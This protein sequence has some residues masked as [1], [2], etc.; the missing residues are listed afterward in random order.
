MLP[1][2][3]AVI[4]VAY[5]HTVTKLFVREDPEKLLEELTAAAG[6]KK[7][8]PLRLK[9][10]T[11]KKNNVA[12]AGGPKG[13]EKS[14]AEESMGESQENASGSASEAADEE[15]QLLQLAT[16]QGKIVSVQSEGKKGHTKK[17]ISSPTVAEINVD[18]D[19]SNGWTRVP[20]KEEETV[21]TLKNKISSL[22]LQLEEVQKAAEGGKSRA[23]KEQKRAAEAEK[24]LKERTRSYQLRWVE[25]ESELTSLRSSKSELMNKL[26]A[27]LQQETKAQI[28]AETIT[29]LQD[30]IILLEA[31][32]AQIP[33]LNDLISA[34]TKKETQLT[35]EID[36]LKIQLDQTKEGISLEKALVEQ[37]RD[38]ISIVI[39][40]RT[41]LALQ[42]EQAKVEQKASKAKLETVRDELSEKDKELDLRHTCIQQLEGQLDSL[43]EQLERLDNEKKSLVDST[44]I[45]ELKERINKVV[46]SEAHLNQ[47]LSESDAKITR[48][49]EELDVMQ[50]EKRQLVQELAETRQSQEALLEKARDN[51]SSAI[52]AQEEAQAIEK[53]ELMSK[54]QDSEDR[55][56]EI[57]EALK[58]SEKKLE[59]MKNVAEAKYAKYQEE[60]NTL[61]ASNMV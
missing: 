16:L 35:E 11:L 42:L 27:A 34:L 36:F 8:R 46:E 60:I 53:Q 51:V 20:T 48:L 19:K 47:L 4:I 58:R 2:A 26:E 10:A 7:K 54:L 59:I 25:M 28:Y 29:S 30:R 49:V 44:Q 50:G 45:D 32:T 57:V 18:N 17:E 14:S 22:V 31:E 13:Q 1:I 24:E 15:E 33:S 9:S 61:K 52:S 43:K 23:E 12:A 38:Q 56:A 40:E 37:L 21:A 5:P 6:K 3:A 39:E 41:S 55:I